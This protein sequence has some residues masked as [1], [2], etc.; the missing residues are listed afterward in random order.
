MPVP[1][2]SDQE[3]MELWKLHKSAA[4]VA[5]VIGVSRQAVFRRRRRLEKKYDQP[6][7]AADQTRAHNW[8]STAHE[9]SARHHLGI[10]NGTVIVF[11]DAHFWPGI[12]T[13]AFK[14]LLWAIKELKPKAVINGGDAFDGAAISRFPRV[15]WDSKP[16]VIEELKACEMYLGEIDDEAKRAYSKA[17]LIW[18][19]GNHDARFENRLANTVPEFMHV[20]GFKLKDHFPD[21]I[22]CWSC[23][24]TEDVV[25]KHRMKGGVHATHNNTVNSGKSI[26]TGHLHSLKVTPFSDYNGERFGVDTGTLA[27]PAGPQFVDYLEDNPTNWRSGF[28]VLTFHN[29]RLLWPELVHAMAPGF[30][31]FRGQVIDVSKL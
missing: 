19:L 11:S 28:S 29:S 20:G 14:G 12:R 3:F 18:A 22:P 17:K 6:M 27:E 13:T 25:V 1:A 9:H 23:W 10:E 31:Q 4:A 15:G 2:I 7:K 30:I 21:W 5:D 26:V 8:I 24:P 16:S